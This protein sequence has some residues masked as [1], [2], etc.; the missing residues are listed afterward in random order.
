MEEE[1]HGTVRSFYFYWVNVTDSGLLSQRP[2][3]THDLDL[4]LCTGL[5]TVQ[6]ILKLYIMI[7]R[8]QLWIHNAILL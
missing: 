5:G 4:Y 3:L 1:V 6:F 7:F 8:L 2:T